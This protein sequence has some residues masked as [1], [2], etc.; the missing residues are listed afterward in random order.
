MNYIIFTGFVQAVLALLF[1]ASLKKREAGDYLLLLLLGSVGLHLAT[2]FFIFNAVDNSA[3]T[4]RMHTCVQ[5]SY[6]PLLYLYAQKRKNQDFLPVRKWYLFIPLIIAITLYACVFFGMSRLP[7]QA[8]LILGFYNQMAFVP[9]VASHISYGIFSPAPTRL[10]AQ[11]KVC[12]VALGVLEIGLYVSGNINPEWNIYARC[13]IYILLG[14]MP[15]LMVWDRVRS[16]VYSNKIQAEPKK[17]IPSEERKPAVPA[18]MHKAIFEKLETLLHERQLYK[19]EDLSL[20]KLC[21]EAGL[22]RH[23]V[24]ET[25]NVFAGKSFYQ[26]INEYRIKE[27]LRQLDG[28]NKKVRLLTVAY[29]SGFKTKASFN[30][31]FKKITGTTPSGYLKQKAA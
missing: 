31:Y 9:I 19:D 16:S 5:F 14:S 2:K 29:D 3:V 17:E 8:T 28:N 23:H 25:L 13:L 24:S 10:A 11:L 1:I 22:N 26:Y 4:F 30:Q 15:V 27:V 20:E 6:G 18:V 7:A 12:L 21:T